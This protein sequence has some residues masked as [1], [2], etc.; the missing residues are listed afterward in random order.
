M[1]VCRDMKHKAQ[2][3]H[4]RECVPMND[5]KKSSTNPS[6]YRREDGRRQS[7]PRLMKSIRLFQQRNSETETQGNYDD[8]DGGSEATPTCAALNVRSLIVNPVF[9]QSITVPGFLPGIGAWY[10][11]SWR[12]GS[13]ESPVGSNGFTPY[14]KSVC[15]RRRCVISTP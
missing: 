15:R 9:W 11:A 5:E 12:F 2:R 14:L 10:S 6:F 13:N 7:A 3:Q 4:V 1:R 8:P